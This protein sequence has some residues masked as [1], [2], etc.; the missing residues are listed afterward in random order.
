MRGHQVLWPS[1]SSVWQQIFQGYPLGPFSHE[2]RCRDSCFVDKDWVWLPVRKTKG[3]APPLHTEMN[4]LPLLC[5][6]KTPVLGCGQ[7]RVVFKIQWLFINITGSS[8]WTVKNKL[9]TC[10]VKAAEQAGPWHRWAGRG[11]AGDEGEVCL[12]NTAASRVFFH[13][14]LKIMIWV[15]HC[16]TCDTDNNDWGQN[17]Y[18][19]QPPT[20]PFTLNMT[21]VT[22]V[23]LFIFPGTEHSLLLQRVPGLQ[24]KQT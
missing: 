19:W 15:L 8:C 24:S 11:C 9:S 6:C 10:A 7:G 12:S 16:L 4:L 14:L 3:L 5:L 23:V 13:K 22:A 18:V 21:S 2:S 17:S 1:K 20:V